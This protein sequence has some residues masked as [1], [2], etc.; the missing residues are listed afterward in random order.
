MSGQKSK[1]GSFH[2]THNGHCCSWELVCF[3]WQTIPFGTTSK[4]EKEKVSLRFLSAHATKHKAGHRTVVLLD[5]QESCWLTVHRRWIINVKSVY[6]KRSSFI[7]MYETHIIS[8][9]GRLLSDM[10]QHSTTVLADKWTVAAHPSTYEIHL[11]DVVNGLTHQHFQVSCNLRTPSSLPPDGTLDILIWNH[12]N[13]SHYISNTTKSCYK[14]PDS[15][16]M[17]RAKEFFFLISSVI[18]QDFCINQNHTLGCQQHI[19]LL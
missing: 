1:S 6:L 11:R 14:T 15:I 8:W 17:G 18:N 5:F 9:G 12:M 2:P 3:F 7:Y 13:I 10:K 19:K 4:T 16:P